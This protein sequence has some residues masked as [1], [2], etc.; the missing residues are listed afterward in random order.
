M[1]KIK[2]MNIFIVDNMYR[3]LQASDKTAS[4]AIFKIGGV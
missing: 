4:E 3:R 1:D 2:K